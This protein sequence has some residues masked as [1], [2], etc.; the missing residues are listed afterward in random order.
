MMEIIQNHSKSI[1]AVFALIIFAAF[2]TGCDLKDIPKGVQ[3]RVELL[4]GDGSIVIKTPLRGNYFLRFE[5]A[6]QEDGYFLADRLD[7]SG[8]GFEFHAE[9]YRRP[10][11]NAK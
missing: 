10:L 11:V 5:N 4:Q 8:R 3:S 9:N 2:A 7:I 1:L 6:R